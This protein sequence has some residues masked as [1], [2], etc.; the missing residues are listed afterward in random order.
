MLNTSTLSTHPALRLRF[1]SIMGGCVTR[2]EIEGVVERH[3]V[4]VGVV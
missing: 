4:V 3:Q 1:T 2:D